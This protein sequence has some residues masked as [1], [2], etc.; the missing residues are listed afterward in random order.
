MHRLASCSTLTWRI[1]GFD[2]ESANSHIIKN[3][4]RDDSK[5]L[6]RQC[7]RGSELR[8]K[9]QY[10]NA[11]GFGA[12]TSRLFR[13]D[14]I[15]LEASGSFGARLTP[16]SVRDFTSLSHEDETLYAGRA[17]FGNLVDVAVADVISHS[18]HDAL[19]AQQDAYMTAQLDNNEMANASLAELVMERA[20]S[21]ISSVRGWAFEIEHTR[22]FN[23]DAIAKGLPW[24]AEYL[25][26]DSKSASDINI[27]D[28]RTGEVVSQVQCKSSDNAAWVRSEF[29]DES[30]AGMQK[31]TTSGTADRVAE[32]VPGVSD[33]ISYKG[34]QS[35]PES[36]SNADERVMKAKDGHLPEHEVNKPQLTNEQIFDHAVSAALKA[37]VMGG[38]IGALASGG[39]SAYSGKDRKQ[40][41]KDTG[42]GAL[43]G[44][45]TAAASAFASTGIAESSG[46]MAL[47]AG[48]GV[49]VGATVGLAWQLER[50]SHRSGAEK[51]TCQ[52][53]AV[54][55]AA[56][57]ATGALVGQA[58]I[59]VPVIGGL[60]GGI[61]GRVGGAF[62]CG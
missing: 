43:Q 59:P 8:S 54:G 60:I 49:V 7:G 40:V 29:R 12:R 58:L 21:P 3:I 57:G 14:D 22:S 36:T 33:K 24:R 19:Q 62:L 44:S 34:A 16:A 30:Y 47:G 20:N 10:V 26:L 61:V 51:S 42:R 50:C 17:G 46:S 5:E 11:G 56:G 23:E 48:A 13:I 4:Q 27:V 15:W 28:S 52:K 39:M 45:T 32:R 41:L 1:H 18:V 31:V 37:G 6:L 25:G 2:A 38:V 35:A 9:G 55:G 53:V